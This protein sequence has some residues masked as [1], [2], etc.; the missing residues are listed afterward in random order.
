MVK[1]YP[2]KFQILLRA[3][4]QDILSGIPDEFSELQF[5][6]KILLVN[7]FRPDCTLQLLG[8]WF[9][10]NLGVQ[11][12]TDS[13]K[14]LVNIPHDRPILVLEGSHSSSPIFISKLFDSLY[15][16]TGRALCYINCNNCSLARIQL[17]LQSGFENDQWVV[18]E[19]L[20]ENSAEIN[21]LVIAM[22]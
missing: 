7:C 4:Q 6:D 11:L 16:Q 15:R 3:N 18:M 10:L 21:E 9:N 14:L 13:S 12:K 5:F 22:M 19:G 1:D 20:G 8:E 2:E 17:L